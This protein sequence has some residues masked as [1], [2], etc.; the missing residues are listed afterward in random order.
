MTTFAILL[1]FASNRSAAPSHMDG[2]NAW[3]RRGFED[4][5]FLVSGSL[6]PGRGGF[7]LARGTSLE[8]IQQR[9]AEDPFVTHDV[10]QPT[11]LEF[12]AKRAVPELQSLVG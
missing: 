10:V 5:T 11:V 9:V 2:H 4:G 6:K 8:A 1:E 3:L 7:V 12:E